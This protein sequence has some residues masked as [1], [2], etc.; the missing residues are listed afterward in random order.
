MPRNTTKAVRKATISKGI[1]T[2][3]TI[4]YGDE[5]VEH[6]LGPHVPL[7]LY[8]RHYRH[9]CGPEHNGKPRP[10]DRQILE[11]EREGTDCLYRALNALV[12]EIYPRG[13]DMRQP[14]TAPNLG[15]WGDMRR[16]HAEVKSAWA[17]NNGAVV[18]RAGEMLP[19]DPRNYVPPYGATYTRAHHQL[20]HSV[21][22]PHVVT[23]EEAARYG[24]PN[25]AGSTAWT[26]D[27]TQGTTATAEQVGHRWAEVYAEEVRHL[28]G[29]EPNDEPLAAFA[30]LHANLKGYTIGTKEGARIM[31]R[32]KAEGMGAE[33]L[34]A[35]DRIR[36]HLNALLDE[37][38]EEHNPEHVVTEESSPTEQRPMERLEWIP[39]TAA[40]DYI[41]STLAARG[42]FKIPGKRGKEGEPN[43]T[44]LARALLL[45]FDV[46]GKD[47]NSLNAEQLR[48]RLHPKS[49][50]KLTDTKQSRFQ[51]PAS[52]E[53]VIPNADELE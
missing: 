50:G 37:M 5:K 46:K 2:G 36:G 41:F 53:L 19:S 45:A 32:M 51:I 48:V 22:V 23:P 47:G 17:A 43:L 9:W 28:L 34:A 35:F 3:R 21:M 29:N 38:A 7:L 44:A 16:E 25:D 40:F 49:E 52:N 11:L 10:M 15:R 14:T 1:P 13:S 31:E 39:S 18:H 4:S 27:P 24:L 12:E 20:V 30:R 42:Y 8:F 33:V 26:C 6:L